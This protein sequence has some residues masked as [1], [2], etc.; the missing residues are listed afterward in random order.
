MAG[1]PYTR[2]I[3][4]KETMDGTLVE[5]NPQKDDN[6]YEIGESLA[7]LIQYHNRKTHTKRPLKGVPVTTGL[8][9]QPDTAKTTLT[10]SKG[11]IYFKPTREG[12][13]YLTYY[14][15]YEKQN[16]L[17]SFNVVK[18]IEQPIPKPEPTKPICDTSK[19]DKLIAYY[20]RI[21]VSLRLKKEKA[22]K[23]QPKSI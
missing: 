19:W 17:I 9:N 18:S 14:D 1:C 23:N 4:Y 3:L 20:E 8:P 21:L 13:F 2:G 10:D 7:Y 6:I 16:P 15:K 12:K 22:C 11:M 5:L